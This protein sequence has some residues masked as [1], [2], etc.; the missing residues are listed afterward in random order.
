MGYGELCGSFQIFIPLGDHANSWLTQ[1][2][3]WRS[4]FDEILDAEV[5]LQEAAMASDGSKSLFEYTAPFAISREKDLL[6]WDTR[7]SDCAE[8]YLIYTVNTDHWNHQATVVMLLTTI[9][10]ILLDTEYTK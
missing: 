4:W 3:N 1:Y 5:V 7:L 8:K 10:L 9:N 6:F 2:Y